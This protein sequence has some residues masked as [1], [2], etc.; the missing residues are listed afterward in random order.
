MPTTMRPS[1]T[2]AR[3]CNARPHCCVH[4]WPRS[5]T[6]SWTRVVVRTWLSFVFVCAHRSHSHAD[7]GSDSDSGADNDICAA[8]RCSCLY[9]CGSHFSIC[10]VLVYVQALRHTLPRDP[11]TNEVVLN[12]SMFTFALRAPF[13]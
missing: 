6:A 5:N 12:H 13:M 7:S 9:L 3:S 2:S 1:R 10:F 4:S 11:D 8:V